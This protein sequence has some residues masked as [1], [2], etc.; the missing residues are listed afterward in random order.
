[1][2]SQFHFIRL[3]PGVALC[4]ASWAAAP[5]AVADAGRFDVTLDARIVSSDGRPSFLDGGLGKLR[6][7]DESDGLE[8]GRLR[9]AWRGAL[10]ESWH[11]S[12]DASAWSADD[13]NPI[14][15]TEA[16][17]EWRPVPQS[18][19][20]SRLRV[21]AF[22]PPVSLE[23]RA[24]GWT[25]PYFTSSSALNTWVGEELRTIG[26]EYR[27]E[28][29]G[30][31][32][33]SEFDWGVGAALYGWNDPA[34]IIIATRGWALHDR[35]TPLFGRIGT[36]ALAGPVQRVLF[37]EIDDRPGY[38]VH[39][40]VRQA[41]RLE[42]R[43]MWYDNRGDPAAFDPEIVD[44]AWDTTFLSLGA[45]YETPARTTVMAQWLSGV[46]DV[47]P[48]AH[49]RW[50]FDAAYLLVSQQ[51]GQ[52]R[53]SGRVDAFSVDHVRT[54]FPIT[55]GRE[56]GDAWS[57]AWTWQPIEPLEFSA[58]WL[59]VDSEFNWRRRLGEDPRALERSLQLGVRYTLS[60]GR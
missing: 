15:L 57:L 14:D 33:G 5:W 49:D 4:A 3:L 53:I 2:S 12:V 26:A 7:D 36:A 6:Y 31:A 39:G 59:V 20:R 42:V 25:N 60:V 45:R 48:A 35:Q 43:A 13:H 17:L 40:F 46:T 9:L 24:A 56:R 47:G 22:Y 21:G 27:L 1:M 23:H 50:T 30:M 52:H 8:F 28:R 58:E 29:S 44:Y 11:A 10:G 37:E 54:V 38:Y 32:V 19:W 18:A 55:L 41:D 16:V 51:F 34:G